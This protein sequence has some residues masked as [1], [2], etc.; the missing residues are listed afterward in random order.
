MTVEP[1]GGKILQIQINGQR[2][3]AP[4]FT[5][6]GLQFTHCAPNR[7]YLDMAHPRRA[8][9]IALKIALNAAAANIIADNII[10]PLQVFAGFCANKA[11]QMGHRLSMRIN[12]LLP[13]QRFNT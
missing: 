8:A 4:F 13:D 12:T 5:R 6:L 3:I 9:Q 7:I 1:L 2:Q 10:N 11:N